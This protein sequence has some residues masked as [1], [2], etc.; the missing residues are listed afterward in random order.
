MVRRVGQF[1]VDLVKRALSYN[2]PTRLVLNHLDYFGDETDMC[3]CSSSVRRF[4]EY[5]ETSVGKRIDWFG[6]SGRHFSQLNR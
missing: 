4:V 5:V 2:A 6:F 1:D 3:N